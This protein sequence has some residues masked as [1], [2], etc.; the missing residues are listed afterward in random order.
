M[1]SAK[2]YELPQNDER[3]ADMQRASRMCVLNVTREANP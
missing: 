3:T 2:R 1:E